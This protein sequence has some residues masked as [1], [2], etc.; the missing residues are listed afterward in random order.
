MDGVINAR[1]PIHGGGYSV[2]GVYQSGTTNP[3]PNGTKQEELEDKMTKYLLTDWEINGYDDSDFM[4]S[5]YDDVANKI[6]FHCYGSTRYAAPTNIG[7]ANGITSVVVDGDT[8]IMPTAEVV[9]K[10]RLVLEE[11]IFQRMTATDKRIA[12]EPDVADLHKGLRVRLLV[13]A[14]MQ[15][16]AMEPCQKCNGS[17]KWINPRNANDKRDCF[18]CKGTGLHVGGKVQINGK[19]AYDKLTAG[20]AGE[21]LDWTSFGQ[22]YANGYN[23]PGRHNTTVQFK[24][25]GG[26]MVRASLNK[27]RLDRELEEPLVL[28]D[29]AKALSFH[30]QF[31]ALTPGKFA[32]DT[33]NHALAI[34]KGAE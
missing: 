12:E 31:S 2:P 5:Y 20:L 22:F 33:H 8:V 18:G 16:R 17:G 27:L 32:W 10:A 11:H 26:K 9:E 15:I 24:T 13:D 34:A 19:Q 30:Y 4:C 14:R 3:S 7:I 25:D 21:V 1:H 29:K 28:R 6:G 23:K